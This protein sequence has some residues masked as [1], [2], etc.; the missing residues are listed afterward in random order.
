VSV[1]RRQAVRRTMLVV[2]SNLRNG[3]VIGSLFAGGVLLISALLFWALEARADNPE[4]RSV[5]DGFLWVTRTLLQGEPPFEPATLVGNI[6]YYIVVITGVGIIAL[7]TGAIASK[8][9]EW[10]MRRDQGMGEAGYE[11]HIVMCGWSPEGQQ[12]LHELHAEEVVDKVPVAIVAPLENNPTEDDLTTFIRGSPN[13]TD[14]L[15]RA[16][17]E[18]AKTAIILADASNRAASADERDAMTLLTALA[19]ESVNPSVHTCVEVI[20]AGNRPHF[21]RAKADELVVSSEMTG[22]LLAFSAMNHGL[23]RVVA[24]LTGHRAGSEFYTPEAPPWLDGTTFR[25]AM[26]EVKGRADAVLLG[27]ARDAGE[28]EVNPPAD[29]VIRRGERLLLISGTDPAERLG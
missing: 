15:R 10:V 17:I 5:W 4:V 3:F 26:D 7:A 19:V 24:D 13:D 25:R 1:L 27:V 20:R 16:G 6:L 28:F 11:D 2:G 21:A 9:I 29:R 12:I 8:L 23:S 18:R 14:T 22:S